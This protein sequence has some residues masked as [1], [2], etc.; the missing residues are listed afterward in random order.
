MNN[1]KPKQTQSLQDLDKMINAQKAVMQDRISRLLQQLNTNMHEREQILAITLLGAISGQ[2][3]FL[4][5]PPGTAKS[6]ISRRLSYAFETSNYFECLMN[7]FTTPEEIF[8]PISI[9]ELK[10]DRYI[11]QIEGYLPT[12]DF[13][14]LDEIWKSSP[15]ILNN[16]LT[17]INE[18]IFKNGNE[19]IDVPLKSLISASNEVPAENQGLDAL[20]DRFILRLLVP[21]IQGND[22][23]NQLLNSKPSSEKLNISP[24]LIISTKELG[25]WREQLHNVSLSNDTLL[26][27][28]YIRQELADK[29]DELKVYVSDR[30]WQRAA[31]LL[32]ASAFCNGRMETNHSDVVLLKYCLWTTPENREEVENIVMEAIKECGFDSGI[33]LADLD[34]EKDKLDKEIHK[35]LYHSKDIYDTVSLANKK[36]YFKVNANFKSSWRGSQPCLI[37]IDYS[38]FKNKDNFYPVDEN[39]NEMS[40]F[41]C[42]FNKQGS[43]IIKDRQG[44]YDDFEFIPK[45]LFHK[46]DKKDDINKRLIKSLS[47]S[48]KEIRQELTEV[49]NLVEDKNKKY[50]EQLQSPFVSENEIDIAVSGI[51]EQIEQLKLRIADCERLESLC[52]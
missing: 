27:I 19:R 45:P 11:R 8:G 34:R 24:E 14:F 43:C 3:T 7:R 22:N 47:D 38:N 13:A 15:A 31:L 28:K 52:Q 44:D 42:N 1:K 17:I 33:D 50:K 10:A 5:G 21:P 39:G 23:F 9:Q 41:I 35:E 40:R 18:H 48:I 16:L 51:L 46:G 32:K 26:I 2:N 25:Q 49:L 20:Y 37:Y 30:R 4:Y 6:L 12:A 29:F 36:K